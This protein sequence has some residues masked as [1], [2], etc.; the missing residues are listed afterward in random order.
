MNKKHTSALFF[1]LLFLTLFACPARAGAFDDVPE[2]AWYRDAAQYAEDGGLMNGVGQNRFDPGGYV[3]RAMFVTMLHRLAGRPETA[4]SCPFADVAPGAWYEKSV[5]WAAAS[6]VVSGYSDLS[7]RPAERMSREQMAAVCYRFA[8]YRGYDVSI[9]ANCSSYHDADKIH[10]WAEDALGWSVAAGLLKGVGGGALAPRGPSTRAQAAAVLMRFEENVI[11]QQ[12]ET[13]TLTV[14]TYHDVGQSASDMVITPQMLEK[15]FV[16]LKKAGYHT[17]LPSELRDYVYHGAPLPQ[18]P[19]LITFDDGYLSNATVAYPLL[20]K[21]D[22]KAAIFIIGVSFGADTYKDT[23]IAISPHFGAKEAA[24]M[25]ASSRVEFGSHT[26]DLHQWTPYE[27]GPEVR[28]NLKKLPTDTDEKY[29]AVLREDA[30]RFAEF[31]AEAIGGST[32]FFAYPNGVVTKEAAAVLREAG[33]SV[34]F[35]S[36]RG[37]N[38]IVQG[39]PRSLTCLKRFNVS[40]DMTASQLLALIGQ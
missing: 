34:T 30:E 3:D 27:E 1:I 32:D 15:H 13:V 29:I 9:C 33:Y 26:F 12:A 40:G 24:K 39:L 35:A 17:I 38:T 23:G 14:L 31:Y 16:A 20:K 18:K 7:F 2:G 28:E 4:A 11:L 5:T 22:L 19:L 6:G 37:V 10:G 25:R 21:Y 36:E 8:Q